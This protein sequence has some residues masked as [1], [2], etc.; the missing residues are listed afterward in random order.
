VVTTESARA[1]QRVHRA[2]PLAAAAM[3]R[4]LAAAALLAADVKEAF[5]LEVRLKGGGPLGLVAAEIRQA[6]GEQWLRVRVDH[7]EVDLPLRPD[8]KLAVGQAIGRDGELV[9]WYEDVGGVRYQSEVPLVSGEIGEDLAHYYWQSVQVPSAVALGV[10]VGPSGLVAA[11]GGVVVQ[12][13]PGSE[14]EVDAVTA[15]FARLAALSQRLND[16]ETPEDL[17]R[18]VLPEPL[19]WSPREPLRFRC[20]CSRRRSLSL[21]KGLPPEELTALIEEQHGAEVVCHYC[22]RRYRFTEEELRQVQSG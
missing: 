18:S 7:P 10:L 5:R 12:A 11:S 17:I 3:G 14:A 13:L 9:V 20:Q 6:E 1:A 8:G 16:G 15:R 4:A 22:R 21:L 2:G 19:R